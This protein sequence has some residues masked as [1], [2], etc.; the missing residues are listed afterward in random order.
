MKKTAINL[1]FDEVKQHFEFSDELILSANFAY[2]MAKVEEKEQIMNAFNQGMN[3]SV[4]YFK[5]ETNTDEANNY[6][7]ETFKQD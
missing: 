4:D 2:A 6:Y 7:N 5:P 3:F 1:F